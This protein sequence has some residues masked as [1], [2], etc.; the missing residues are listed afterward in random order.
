MQYDFLVSISAEQVVYNL[1]CCCA[2]NGTLR[3]EVQFV[4]CVVQRQHSTGK[5]LA[6]LT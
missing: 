6:R 4:T 1:A 5:V 3:P 2:M